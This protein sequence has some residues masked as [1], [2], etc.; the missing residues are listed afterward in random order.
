M[1]ELA[2]VTTFRANCNI[3]KYPHCGANKYTILFLHTSLAEST[4]SHI[5]RA[6]CRIECTLARIQAT[7]GSSGYEHD[8]PRRIHTA[9]VPRAGGRNIQN[10]L[11]VAHYKHNPLTKRSLFSTEWRGP[12]TVR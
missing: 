1:N 9:Y 8:L 2:G 4:E 12:G 7:R 11:G 5:P 6:I 3:L 10:G